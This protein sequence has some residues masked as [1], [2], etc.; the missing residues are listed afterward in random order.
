[1]KTITIYD[2]ADVGKMID[3]EFAQARPNGSHSVCFER[4]KFSCLHWYGV[5][6]YFLAIGATPDDL[7]AEIRRLMDKHDPLKKLR[8]Q[9]A[10]A[11]FLLVAN[12]HPTPENQTH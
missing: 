6:D 3:A 8:E 4:G 7:A 12:S 1:M 9:A 2:P 11:G 10:A 5:K